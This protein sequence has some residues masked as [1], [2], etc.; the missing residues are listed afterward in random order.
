MLVLPGILLVYFCPHI[1]STS[2]S[3]SLYLLSFSVVLT[4]VLVSRGIVI[5]VRR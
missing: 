2:I 3:K 4:E 1:L 5:S